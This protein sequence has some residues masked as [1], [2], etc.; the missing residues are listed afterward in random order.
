M[1]TAFD[2]WQHPSYK[3]LDERLRK[4]QIGGGEQRIAKQH[5][6]GKVRE[7]QS[8]QGREWRVAKQDHYAQCA[9]IT[10]RLGVPAKST[11]EMLCAV[12]AGDEC[13]SA[14][15]MPRRIVS[16][17]SSISCHPADCT[18]AYPGA[19]GPWLVRGVW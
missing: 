15:E 13:S 4:A 5:Q 17:L 3:A 8:R 12:A 14:K 1:P 7:R 11:S 19:R 9:H 2:P 10:P 16:I 6:S 18:G